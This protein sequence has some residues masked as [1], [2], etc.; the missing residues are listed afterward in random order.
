[1]YLSIFIARHQ[2]RDLVCTHRV[3]DDNLSRQLGKN[4]G[5]AVEVNKKAP[6]AEKIRL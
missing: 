3:T 6:P 5:V 1:M 4:M 2:F